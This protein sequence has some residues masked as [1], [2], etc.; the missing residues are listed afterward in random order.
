MDSG[1]QRANER[2]EYVLSDEEAIRIYE[3]REKA[4]WDMLSREKRAARLGRE[5]G[6]TLGREQNT[7]EIAR[8]MKNAGRP[9]DEIAGF[10][11]LTQE[12]IE[13]L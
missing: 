11:G 1:I 6:F 7:L 5:E 4:E 8:R 3:A 10:T 13:G 12:Q 9:F 2:Q